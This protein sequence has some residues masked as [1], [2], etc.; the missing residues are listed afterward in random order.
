MQQEKKA[1][2]SKQSKLHAKVWAHCI[3]GLWSESWTHAIQLKFTK[4][5]MLNFAL[6]D[7]K[8]ILFGDPSLE[9]NDSRIRCIRAAYLSYAG[10]NPKS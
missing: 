2:W 6:S 7:A 10:N 5:R 9:T 1:D 8:K 4:D 3:V